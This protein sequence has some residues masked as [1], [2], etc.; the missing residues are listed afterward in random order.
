LV[1]V[2]T[3]VP[4]LIQNRVICLLTISRPEVLLVFQPDGSVHVVCITRQQAKCIVHLPKGPTNSLNISLSLQLKGNFPQ[5]VT[6]TVGLF[7][8]LITGHLSPYYQ[9]K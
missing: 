3:N 5:L 2:R 8:L 7:V 6:Y 4:N 9:N 1:P